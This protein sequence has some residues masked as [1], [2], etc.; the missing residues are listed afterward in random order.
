MAFSTFEEEISSE[1]RQPVLD[2]KDNNIRITRDASGVLT[3]EILPK[4]NRAVF[5]LAIAYVVYGLFGIF[6]LQFALTLL[7]HRHREPAHYMAI[8]RALQILDII[9]IGYF[10]AVWFTG[11]RILAL[12]LSKLEIRSFLLGICTNRKSFACSDVRNL[13]YEQWEVKSQ[14]K[15][16]ERTGIRFE[17]GLATYTFGTSVPAT[18]AAEI[19][20]KVREICPAIVRRP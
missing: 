15:T 13:C 9:L 3:V 4:R 17:A 6:A 18:R 16:F 7:Q 12:S 8:I 14:N 10:L 19:I 5:K 11:R 1:Q 2:P 20:R